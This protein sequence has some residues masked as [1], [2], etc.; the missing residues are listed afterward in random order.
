MPRRESA[1]AVT[2]PSWPFAR[3][4]NARPTERE[5]S[6]SRFHPGIG[7]A[8]THSVRPHRRGRRD[9]AARSTQ[10]GRSSVG[11][12]RRFHSFPH[13][14]GHVGGLWAGPADR[15]LPGAIPLARSNL[16]NRCGDRFDW[17]RRG[18]AAPGSVQRPR[19]GTRFHREAAARVHAS[20]VRSRFPAGD[21][22]ER[23]RRGV[24]SGDGG[25]RA[26]A[27]RRPAHFAGSDHLHGGSR[28]CASADRGRLPTAAGGQAAGDTRPVQ[29][30]LGA[31][32]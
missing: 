22:P 25:D 28:H 5:V 1:K 29:R 3:M 32:R 17:G 23:P 10:R 4:T 14:A 21:H 9:P 16:R 27:T 19:T 6:G 31:T 13:G 26:A 2:V 7:G 8:G 18:A 11:L 20:A 12:P 15:A 30:A 24:P